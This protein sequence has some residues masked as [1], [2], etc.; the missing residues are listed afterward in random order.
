MY[1]RKLLTP[2][3][4]CESVAFFHQSWHTAADPNRSKVTFCDAD[5]TPYHFY[6]VVISSIWKTREF[7]QNSISGIFSTLLP[8]GIRCGLYIFFMFWTVRIGIPG[9]TWHTK[10]QI[11]FNMHFIWSNITICCIL[12]NFKLYSRLGSTWGFHNF[13]YMELISVLCMGVCVFSQ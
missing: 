10:I 13:A 11:F 3:C 1:R 2:S 8:L 9:Y 5:K 7:S 12:P 6:F 4:R